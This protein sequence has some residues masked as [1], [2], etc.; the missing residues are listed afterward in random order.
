M[1]FRCCLCGA[2]G[3]RLSTGLFSVSSQQVVLNDGVRFHT[4][5]SL[6]SNCPNLIF[7]SDAALFI[8]GKMYSP[9]LMPYQ[10]GS[11]PD[12]VSQLRAFDE[13]FG[14]KIRHIEMIPN[15]NSP[16]SQF[17]SGRWKPPTQTTSVRQI[18]DVQ[19]NGVPQ[20]TMYLWRPPP[21]TAVVP[22]PGND[23]SFYQPYKTTSL[24]W[25]TDS[26]TFMH[27]PH[28]CQQADVEDPNRDSEDED[29]DRNR[30]DDAGT[31][32][33]A[34]GLQHAEQPRTWRRLRFQ[35]LYR[36]P[37]PTIS[38]VGYD[39]GHFF[40]GLLPPRWMGNL[41]PA[42]HKH[43]TNNY[44]S[45]CQLSGR[46]PTVLGL[47]A[48]CHAEN[49]RAI[50]TVHSWFPPSRGTT[51]WRGPAAAPTNHPMQ[52]CDQREYHSAHLGL[53]E[54]DESVKLTV[55]GPRRGMVIE[56]FYDSRRLHTQERLETWERGLN[57]PI[58][59]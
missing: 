22:M 45:D 11:I 23:L 2:T 28:D 19:Y 56:T 21:A 3:V 32:N 25:A 6:H 47:V 17:R 54:R 35:L 24:F 48:F 43:P 52:T 33:Q 30:D 55:P 40:D 49:T 27:V 26:G 16:E 57:G 1:L 9:A 46:L 50:D 29:E 10:G 59:T 8:L 53:T 37:H 39:G 5:L 14:F 7:A 34:P 15:A 4:F 58:I 36:F 38:L 20:S 44:T 42:V 51:H 12:T 18:E 31:S 41:M 13:P